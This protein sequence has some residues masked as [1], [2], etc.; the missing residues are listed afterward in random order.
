MGVLTET[1]RSTALYVATVKGRVP[2]PG[3]GLGQSRCV[4]G[5]IREPVFRLFYQFGNTPHA[6][7]Y[8]RSAGGEAL[9]DS[10]RIVLIPL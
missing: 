3:H 9:Y 6:C 4:K 10:E 2:D 5:R 8:H 7:P 1:S